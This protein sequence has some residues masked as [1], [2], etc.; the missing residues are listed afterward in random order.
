MSGN[1]GTDAP[2]TNALRRQPLGFRADGKDHKSETQGM[3]E[4]EDAAR[5]A[6]MEPAVV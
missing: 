5:S 6:P 4:S 3:R 1:L 2:G